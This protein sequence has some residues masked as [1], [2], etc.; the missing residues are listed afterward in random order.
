MAPG[1]RRQAAGTPS[2]SAKELSARA[3]VGPTGQARDVERLCD[4]LRD[5]TDTA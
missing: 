4:L 2:V 1:G 5:D 3:N